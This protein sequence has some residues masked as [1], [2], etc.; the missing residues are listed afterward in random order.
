MAGQFMI[1]FVLA[2]FFMMPFPFAATIR[3]LFL[4]SWVMPGLV[5]GAHLEPGSSRAI[6][7]C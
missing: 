2:L 3:G 6:S 1:G 4:V 7:A 5:V